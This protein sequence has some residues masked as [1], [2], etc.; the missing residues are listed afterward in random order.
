MLTNKTTRALL[1]SFC[2]IFP[3][4]L[5]PA[6][7]QE[8]QKEKM[9]LDQKHIALIRRISNLAAPLGDKIDSCLD[10]KSLFD[11]EATTL[12][13]TTIWNNPADPAQLVAYSNNDQFIVTKHARLI[14]VWDTIANTLHRKFEHNDILRLLAISSDGQTIAAVPA[15]ENDLERNA[16]IHLINSTTG[17][18]AHVIAPDHLKKDAIRCLSALAFNNND[19]VLSTGHNAVYTWDPQSHC[20]KHTHHADHDCYITMIKAFANGN[21]ASSSSTGIMIGPESDNA[22]HFLPD[23]ATAL[24]AHSDI[25]VPAIPVP[26]AQRHY[27]IAYK[28]NKRH[29]R[30]PI[31]GHNP[32]KEYGAVEIFTEKVHSLALNNDYKLIVGDDKKIS[33]WNWKQFPTRFLRA[34]N[35]SAQGIPTVSSN[36][37]YVLTNANDGTK[38]VIFKPNPPS[39]AIA[40]SA[41]SAEQRLAQ[42][43]AQ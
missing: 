41:R 3:S 7:E 36:G 5:Y 32:K 35:F 39:A 17:Q 23:S 2:I 16:S 10:Y 24:A 19:E 28:S 43:T 31:Y 42:A 8:E 12:Y 21:I 15:D 26:K 34:F 18:L 20:I 6:A 1:F 11:P 33:I 27:P 4:I 25:I 38:L 13:P 9:S 30:V 14:R 37:G 40:R 22:N 29:T